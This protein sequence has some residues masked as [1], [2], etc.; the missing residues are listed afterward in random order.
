MRIA[1]AKRQTCNNILT[2]TRKYILVPHVFTFLMM[3]DRRHRNSY[4]VMYTAN[5][6]IMRDK[7]RITIFGI[8]TRVFGCLT[9]MWHQ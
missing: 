5:M 4:V 8:E 9:K 2:R 3:R 7:A 1:Y 6:L